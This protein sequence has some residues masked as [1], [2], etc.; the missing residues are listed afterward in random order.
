M[1]VRKHIPSIPIPDFEKRL[2]DSDEIKA[3]KS[4]TLPAD[5]ST[6]MSAGPVKMTYSDI[7]KRF[8]ITE[9][10]EVYTP[11]EEDIARFKKINPAVSFVNNS[12]VETN[13]DDKE[14]TELPHPCTLFHN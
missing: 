8:G 10:S 6:G 12:I 11:T 4:R 1:S 13:P 7:V 14:L 3:L 9:P 5:P 2:V